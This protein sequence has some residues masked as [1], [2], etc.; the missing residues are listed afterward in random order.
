MGLSEPEYN[1]YTHHSVI[2][3][4]K[5]TLRFLKLG[6]VMLIN[7]CSKC[8][9]SSKPRYY[10]NTHLLKTKIQIRMRMTINTS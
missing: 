2:K 7:W 10:I 5:K 9:S 4:N 3:A 6:L 1:L 8:F